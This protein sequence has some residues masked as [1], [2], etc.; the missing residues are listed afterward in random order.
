MGL[1]RQYKIKIMNED[2][3]LEPIWLRVQDIKLKLE[4]NQKEYKERQELL[5]ERLKKLQSVCTHDE[6]IISNDFNE[7]NRICKE[8]GKI[9]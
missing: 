1:T 5:L 6:V 2:T 4:T 3:K 7:P 9:L 8:C